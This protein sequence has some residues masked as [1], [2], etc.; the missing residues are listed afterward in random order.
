MVT[1]V[2]LSVADEMLKTCESAVGKANVWTR[3]PLGVN[4]SM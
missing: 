1:V 3:V 4:S 2:L